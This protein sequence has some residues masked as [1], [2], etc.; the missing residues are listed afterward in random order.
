MFLVMS[1]VSFFLVSQ[2]EYQVCNGSKDPPFDF[3]FGSAN[4]YMRKERGTLHLSQPY[5]LIQ[6]LSKGN[7][8]VELP[9]KE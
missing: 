5:F 9:K 2:G 1:A 7:F 4:F 6:I 3:E 8:N